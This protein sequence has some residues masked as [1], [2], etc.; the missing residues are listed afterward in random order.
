M[1]PQSADSA[2][3]AFKAAPPVNIWR[4]NKTEEAGEEKRKSKRE[5]LLNLN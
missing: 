2:A 3:S 4:R 5:R 1:Y